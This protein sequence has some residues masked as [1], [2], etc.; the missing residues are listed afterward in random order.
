MTTVEYTLGT[1]A[2]VGFVFVLYKVISSPMVSDGLTAVLRKALE[3]S[4]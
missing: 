2:A 3:T 1:L 4:F